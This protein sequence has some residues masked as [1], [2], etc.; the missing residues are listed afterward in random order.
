MMSKIVLK[1]H[2]LCGGRNIAIETWTRGGR[3][4]MVKCNNPDCYVPVNGYPTGRNLEEVK[5]EWNK[6]AGDQNE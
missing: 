5:A 6:R 1:P 3:M 2:P 4:Y